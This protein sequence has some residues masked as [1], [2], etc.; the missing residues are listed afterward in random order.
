MFLEELHLIWSFQLQFHNNLTPEL[1]KAL[2][3]DIN[4]T[5]KEKGG[6]IFSETIKVPKI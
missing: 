1:K 4:N 6:Y 3:G 5:V 2:I